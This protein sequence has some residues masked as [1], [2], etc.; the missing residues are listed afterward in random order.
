[1]VSSWSTGCVDMEELVTSVAP[2]ALEWL[3]GFVPSLGG[4]F[5]AG[6]VVAFI[7]W[8]IGYTVGSVYTWLKGR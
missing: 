6:V 4:F 5:A 3:G 1:M 2:D 7:F 8:T